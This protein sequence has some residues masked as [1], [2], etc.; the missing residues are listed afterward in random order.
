[1]IVLC[2]FKVRNVLKSGG[3]EGGELVFYPEPATKAISRQ[4]CLHKQ[5]PHAEKE[6]HS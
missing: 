6:Q 2:Y 5:M 3:L 1:M 4:P